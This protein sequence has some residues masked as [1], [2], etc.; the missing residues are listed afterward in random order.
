MDGVLVDS[1]ACWWQVLR[2]L[3][4]AEGKEPLT[5][6]RFAETW[7]QDMD[8]DRSTFFPEWTTAE[9]MARYAAAFPSYAHLI[10]AEPEAAATL[11]TLHRQGKRLA[12]ATNSPVAIATRLLEG[13]GLAPYFEC[14]ACVDMVAEGK[15]AP[16][17]L[18]FIAKELGVTTA[19]IAYVGD[20]DYDAGAARA[21]GLFFVGYRRPGDARVEGLGEL[22]RG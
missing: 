14:I 17:L 19:E 13:A 18:H 16:D 5:R 10:Q 2:D 21:A 7:G 3:L 20:S 22:V 6:E 8:A 15:P 11:A 1:F 4:I 9:L 12:V